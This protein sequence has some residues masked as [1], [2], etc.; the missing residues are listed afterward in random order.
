MINHRFEAPP[1]TYRIMLTNNSPS[2]GSINNFHILSKYYS[3][4]LLGEIHF[5]FL[6]FCDH[7][8]FSPVPHLINDVDICSRR[9][10]SLEMLDDKLLCIHT[11]SNFV[12][13][14]RVCRAADIVH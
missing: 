2:R 6:S 12:L 8:L 3:T 7:T 9:E 10:Q 13:S 14:V 4:H 11:G 5:F 1:M